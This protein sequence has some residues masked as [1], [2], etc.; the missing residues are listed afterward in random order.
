MKS[1]IRRI[2]KLE[3]RYMPAPETAFS[4]EL[5]GGWRRAASAYGNIANYAAKVNPPMKGCHRKKFIRAMAYNGL[6]TF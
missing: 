6:W 2:E 5:L 3:K 4:K 1:I